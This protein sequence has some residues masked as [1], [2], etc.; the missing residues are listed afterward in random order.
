MNLPMNLRFPLNCWLV[1]MW[2]W[3]ASRMRAYVWTRRSLHLRGLV[4]HF[5][6]AHPGGFRRGVVIE[7]IPPRRALGTLRN[8]VVL[9]RGDYRVW[10]FRAVR[11]RRCTT[12]A[13]A[14]AIAGAAR[15]DA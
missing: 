15:D 14:M 1:A 12:L 8:L 7:Y 6:T 3:L 13:D 2:I 10:E 11:V 4:P 9:F 5:G